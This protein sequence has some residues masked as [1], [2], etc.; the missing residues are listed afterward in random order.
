MINAV[1]ELLNKPVAYHPVLARM[2]GNVASAV[3][4][5]QG[6]YWQKIAESKGEE[7]FWVKSDGWKDQCGLSRSMQETAREVLRRSG[8]WFEVKRGIPAQLFFRIDAEIL[9]EKIEAFLAGSEQ[10]CRNVANNETERRRT[11][12]GQFGKQGS[13]NVD[14]IEIIKENSLE[15]L[16]ENN[17]GEKT[18]FV[19]QTIEA[20]ENLKIETVE[21]IEIE[22]LKADP[23]EQKTLPGRGA[24]KKPGEYTDQD[25]ARNLDGRHQVFF[26]EV[27]RNKAWPDFL[28]Y[29][30]A[31]DRR[32]PYRDAKSHAIGIRQLFAACHGNPDLAQA[33]VDQTR[34]NGWTGLFELK[35]SQ[36]NATQQSNIPNYAANQRSVL[37]TVLAGRYERHPE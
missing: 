32:T 3:M 13:R 10:G 27:L 25:V 14:D 8:F 26:A 7:W 30:T 21:I 22:S 17:K 16:L 35:N 18:P 15:T 28:E 20:D 6:M 33:V 29:R 2:T 37:E 31:R 19:I 11:T 1:K 36:K 12:T 23:F 9:V 34:G 4:L 5:S 24:K